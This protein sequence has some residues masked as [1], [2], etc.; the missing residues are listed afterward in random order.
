MKEL[1]KLIVFYC[2][3]IRHAR[4][5]SPS[6]HNT[7]FVCSDCKGIAIAVHTNTCIYSECMQCG[8]TIKIPK[9]KR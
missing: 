8:I 3:T 2:K 7:R 4:M 5:T 1:L 9:D 6:R